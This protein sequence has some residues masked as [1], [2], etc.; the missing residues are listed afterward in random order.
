M[1][2]FL[3]T[4]SLVLLLIAASQSATY[5]EWIPVPADRSTVIS[6][7]VENKKFQIRTATEI[8]N[9]ND[10]RW[11]LGGVGWFTFTTGHLQAYKCIFHEFEGGEAF[12][13]RAGDM[14]FLK[15]STQLQIWFDDVLEVTWVFQDS[16]DGYECSMR[17]IFNGLRFGISKEDTVSTHYRFQTVPYSRWIPLPI[18]RSTLVSE[19]VENKEFQIRTDKKIDDENYIG[20]QLSGFNWFT[21]TSRS[22]SAQKCVNYNLKATET[23]LEKA[24]DMTF[25][26]TSTQLQ[27]WFDGVLEVTWVYENTDEAE[28][29]EMRKPLNGL[30]FTSIKSQ[31]EV[32]TH[33]RYQTVTYS[34]WKPAPANKSSVISEIVENMKFQIRTD[35]KIDGTNDIRWTF[36]GLDPG[37]F[38]FT[39]EHLDAARCTNFVFQ[40]TEPFLERAGDL[41]FLKTSTQL[42][43]WFDDVLEVTWVYQDSDEPKICEMKKSFLGLTLSAPNGN[44]D[45]ISTQYRNQL[46]V[47]PV[48]KEAKKGT[49]MTISCV[50][51]GITDT[52]TVSW[53]TSTGEVSGD[54]F[55]A[56]QGSL[57]G[58]IQTSTLTVDGTNV[59]T[60]IAYTCRVT[61]GLLPDASVFLNVFDVSFTDK[62]VKQGS[63][64]TISCVITGITYTA[65]VSWRTST[66]EVSG[67]KFTAVQGSHSDG[68]QT[69]TLAVDG[70]QVNVD[71]VYTCRVTSGSLPDS[72]SFDTTVNLNVFD[73]KSVNKEVKQGST[74]TISC[75]IT[76]ITDTAT[77]SW[78]TIAGEVLGDEFT[79][80]QGS[81]SGGTQTST[82]AVDGPQVNVDIAYTCRVTSGSLPESGSFNT[83]VNLLVDDAYYSEW[84]KVPE[85]RNTIIKEIMEGKKFQIRTD[86]KID[87]NSD[88]RWTLGGVGD[89]VLAVNSINVNG[90]VKFP[91]QG[92]EPFLQKA[93]EFGF[94]KTS[95]QLKIWFDNVPEVTW[96]FKNANTNLCD[97]KKTLVG[98]SFKST[99]GNPDTVSTYYKYQIETP[100]CTGLPADWDDVRADQKFPVEQD[101][102]IRLECEGGYTLLGSS[103]ITCKQDLQFT[104][105]R[106]PVCFKGV[107]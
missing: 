92:T 103:I 102:E 100:K 68:T 15:T 20:W 2:K 51:T 59:I 26:K 22:L 36:G 84:L 16:S 96:T 64:T 63:T 90:C 45:K 97:M 5:S 70:T 47:T 83:K 95:T 76:G 93:G 27:I 33:Y 65:T 55:T 56:V 14:T 21:L 107:L 43:I 77:V 85:D 94:L 58:G 3:T 87:G 7:I 6:E 73:V 104:F 61:S 38:Q 88:I 67:D 62:E 17:K 32:S 40:G 105:A 28:P 66:G 74:T 78:R 75:V 53:R 23:F 9:N 29:C 79:A 72:G 82:L 11:T 31:D 24:G 60:D 13:K 19:I 34:K 30:K 89:L 46:D 25:L 81:H 69:S 54:K 101:K 106:Q 48:N 1:S 86:K 57:S 49:T 37:W 98:L 52:A 80:D 12:L 39:K 71:T 35:K 44:P 50:I 8:N 4:L 10:I 91:F 18:D 99:N 41:T 42:Q